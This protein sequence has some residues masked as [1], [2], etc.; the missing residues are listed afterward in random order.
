MQTELTQ[1][2]SLVVSASQRICKLPRI[3]ELRSH[4]RDTGIFDTCS[5]E[6]FLIFCR[7]DFATQGKDCKVI[8]EVVRIIQDFHERKKPMGFCCIAP[9]LAAKVIPGAHITLG[10]PGKFFAACCYEKGI[11]G[12]FMVLID[13]FL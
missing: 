9:I 6:L 2:S 12:F 5:N 7:S 4:L 13:V 10:R 11:N 3:N 8:P 1:L